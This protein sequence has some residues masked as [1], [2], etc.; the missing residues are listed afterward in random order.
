MCLYLCT[1]VKEYLVHFLFL[2]NLIRDLN[3]LA[4]MRHVVWLRL[5]CDA[6]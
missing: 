5:V 4:C 2:I 6:V 3:K 1:Q